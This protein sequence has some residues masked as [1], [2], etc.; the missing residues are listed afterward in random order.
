M[1]A[2]SF[3]EAIDRDNL[4]D[5]VYARLCDALVSGRFAPGTRLTI[6]DLAQTLGT[7]VTPVRDAILRLV[8]DGALEQRG[9]RD[10]RVP[11]I[12]IDQ[13]AEIRRI[14]VRLEGLAARECAGRATAADLARL[15]DLVQRN[16]AALAAQDWA[17]GL[18]LNQTFHFALA[19]IAGMAVLSGILKGLWLR[20]GPLI[21]ETY[22]HGGRMMI[23]HHH[24]VVAAVGKRDAD[25]AEAAIAADIT[26]AGD[27]I[28]TRLAARIAR[29][30]QGSAA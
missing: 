27:L 29:E 6:R 25:A 16:E 28:A 12:S 26:D 20:M 4:G 21:A 11:V 30:G 9:L 24:E 7:S 1:R 10:L 8:Q 3:L 5:G 22:A 17:A 19:D 23:D 15:V 14:R 13:Y 2:E 18:E